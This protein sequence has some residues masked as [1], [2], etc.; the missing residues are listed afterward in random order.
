[1]VTTKGLKIDPHK[2]EAVTRWESPRCIKDVQAFLGFANFY[3]RFIR[4]YSKIAAP[5]S[6]LT[7]KDQKAFIFPWSPVGPEQRAFE[8]LKKAFV[9]A[10]ILSHFDLERET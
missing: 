8:D 9:R 10:P 3:R 7:R 4:G 5:L 6:A 1:M 2:V